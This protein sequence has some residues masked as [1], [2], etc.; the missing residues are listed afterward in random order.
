M[1]RQQLK[2][3]VAAR[4]DMVTP[5]G[6][7]VGGSTAIEAPIETIEEEL[8]KA[9]RYVLKYAKRELV[10]PAAVVDLKHFHGTEVNDQDT[11]L[12]VRDDDL[13]GLVVCPDNF[14]RFISMKLDSWKREL[15]GLISQGDPIY[16]YQR[17][18]RYSGGSIYKP[19][20]ALAAFGSYQAAEKTKYTVDKVFTTNQT[21]S[22]LFNGE[23]VDSYAI[24]TGDIL[25]LRG[26]TNYADNGTYKAAASGA[27]T[28]LSDEVSDTSG[29]YPMPNKAI[30]IFRAGSTNDTIESF[31]YIPKLVAEEMP[32]E[33]E[34][35]MIWQCAGNVLESMGD[36][37]LAKI[38]WDQVKIVLDTQKEGL[39]GE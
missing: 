9:A 39:I 12:I 23:T 4:V 24:S 11:R 25:V 1:T 37:N 34:D 38:A 18:N 13:S 33:L 19:T 15:T 36:S 31:I 3:R 26:Q 7:S 2:D 20:G 14:I 32:E 6:D 30:E 10:L 29:N 21:L 27:P 5:T 16:K 35:P 8:D 28:K 22:T 17:N